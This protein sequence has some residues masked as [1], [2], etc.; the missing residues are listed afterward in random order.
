MAVGAGHRDVPACQREPGLLVFG[1]GEGGR[2][3]SVQIMAAV[4][5]IEIWGSGKLTGMAVFV[6]IGAEVELYPV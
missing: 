1:Q 5:S 4:A 2:L 6:A 3:V